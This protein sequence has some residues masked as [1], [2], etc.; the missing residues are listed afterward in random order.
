MTRTLEKW[1]LLHPIEALKRQLNKET[2]DPNPHP[3]VFK[4]GPEGQAWKR[5][6]DTLNMPPSS[7]QLTELTNPRKPGIPCPACGVYFDTRASL[8]SHMSKQYKD[9]AARPVN[10]P[11]REFDKHT[12]ALGGLPRCSHCHVK[13]CDFPGFANTSMNTA[14]TPTPPHPGPHKPPS[15]DTHEITA[16]PDKP[17]SPPGPTPNPHSDPQSPQREPMYHSNVPTPAEPPLR[18]RYT[19]NTRGRIALLSQTSCASAAP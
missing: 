16:I 3:D 10:Q 15:Y 13:L 11:K 8:L 9:H 4:R 12:D 5:V 7:S 2:S 17:A 19:D 6:M 14:E 1:S 18:P